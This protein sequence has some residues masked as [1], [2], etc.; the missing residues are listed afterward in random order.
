MEE[1]RK[2]IIREITKLSY[3]YLSS[4]GIIYLKRRNF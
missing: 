2:I 1:N 4:K 3:N